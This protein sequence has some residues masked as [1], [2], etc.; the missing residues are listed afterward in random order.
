[1]VATFGYKNPM[2]VPKLTKVAINV[3]LSHGIKDPKFLDI[4]EGTVRRITGQQPVRTEAKKSI[5]N[6]K[7]RK[8]M[9]VGMAV[10]LRGKRMYDF[11]EKLVRVTFP[12]IRDFRGL[13][14]SSFDKRGNFTV[15]FRENI[16]FPEIRPDEIER[17]HGLEITVV[18]TAKNKEEGVALLKNIGFPFNED[19][20]EKKS[21]KA[22]KKKEKE[23]VKEVA[24][25]TK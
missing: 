13:K 8:G 16:A 14:P 6:F 9:I 22:R 23:K 19:L 25:K 17:L 2:A 1:M 15:G 24:D 11:V 12:R 7:I 10:T 3:G 20:D 18:T 5:S 21:K 4:A